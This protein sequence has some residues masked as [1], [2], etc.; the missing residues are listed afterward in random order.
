MLRYI[1]FIICALMGLVRGNND[2]D[3]VNT[4][5]E[6]VIDK[7]KDGDPVYIGI[8]CVVGLVALMILFGIL[9]ILRSLCK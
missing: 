7:I 8:A 1:S 9:G 6:G 3:S 5:F 4:F 2:T